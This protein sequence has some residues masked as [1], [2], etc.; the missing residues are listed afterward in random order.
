MELTLLT[1]SFWWSIHS[2]NLDT[3]R[4]LLQTGNYQSKMETRSRV[5]NSVNPDEMA[6][7]KPSH[8]D[9]HCLH[10]YMFG[11]HALGQTIMYG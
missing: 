1:L 11:V 9:I 10:R 7:Y 4:P 8:L 2:L 5:A 6:P 3:S